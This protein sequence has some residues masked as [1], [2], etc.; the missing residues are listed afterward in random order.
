MESKEGLGCTF[1]FSEVIDELPAAQFF[2]YNQVK[3]DP[4]KRTQ[5]LACLG[6]LVA[7]FIAP[8]YLDV[9]PYEEASF[10]KKYDRFFAMHKRLNMFL[11]HLMHIL[12]LNSNPSTEVVRPTAQRGKTVSVVLERPTALDI[13]DKTLSSVIEPWFIYRESKPTLIMYLSTNNIEFTQGHANLLALHKQADHVQL[14]FLNPSGVDDS[15]FRRHLKRKIERICNGTTVKEVVTRCPQLQTEE[16]GSNCVQ[17]FAMFFALVC[18]QPGSFDHIPTLLEHLERH[19]NLNILLFSLSYFLR[20]L[21]VFGLEK[22]YYAIFELAG[23]GR[24]HSAVNYNVLASDYNFRDYMFQ[25]FSKTDCSRY[26]ATDID[27]CPE[28]CV[29]CQGRCVSTDLADLTQGSCH[30]RS[31]KQVAQEMFKAYSCIRALTDMSL[32]PGEQA[33]IDATLQRQLDSLHEVKTLQEYKHLGFL[34]NTQI[35]RIRQE[36]EERPT[37]VRRL[38]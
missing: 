8:H 32:A 12:S 16:Q 37:K 13:G 26:R 17:W 10:L 36:E 11:E 4:V 23:S 14:L 18:S 25:R 27:S 5:Y 29:K 15:T 7:L 9:Y 21:P 1:D 22:Y 28:E 31:P 34:T 38:E 2:W 24:D 3:D 35:D 33:E 30:V 20:T 19:A 6:Q